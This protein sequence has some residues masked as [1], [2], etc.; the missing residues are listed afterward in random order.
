MNE[1]RHTRIRIGA[2]GRITA[3]CTGSLFLAGCAYQP[4]ATPD[5]SEARPESNPPSTA[6]RRIADADR[7]RSIIKA[8]FSTATVGDD[9][10]DDRSPD[11][12]LTAV[13]QSM[14]LFTQPQ[15]SAPN[16]S[17]N[18]SISFQDARQ[19][20]HT[21]QYII[22]KDHP[23][24]KKIE[25]ILRAFDLYESVGSDD[26]GTVQF[27]GYFAPEYDAS[28]VRTARFKYPIY[29]APADYLNL[30]RNS[31][32][33]NGGPPPWRPR[34]EIE[35][36]NLLEG[37]ELAYLDDPLNVYLLQINGSARL[38]FPNGQGK[39]CVGYSATNN[40]PYTSLGKLLIHAGCA[41]PAKM[42]M[43][44][45][46]EIY[47]RKPAVVIELMKQNDR[48]VF[49]E[50][51]DCNHWPRSS[52]GTTLTP[53]RSIAA[54]HSIFPPGG[55]VVVDLNDPPVDL[56]GD[57]SAAFPRFMLNQDTGGAIKGPARADL[58]IGVGPEAGQIAGRLN[59]TGRLYCLIIKKRNASLPISANVRNAN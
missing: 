41:T 21:F 48:Y 49:F 32:S 30:L 57:A 4:N 5:Q 31:S 50:Q 29:R 19:S 14:A 18:R 36:H 26:F 6:L 2:A 56:T 55:I 44:K 47:E 16:A 43:Q 22:T 54:D 46:R 25:A 13:R 3:L 42:S 53:M 20:L 28:F 59:N 11:S 15:H 38:R 34:R 51:L 8:A 1:P 17:R 35:D 10:I 37:N 12:L 58:F 39:I 7:A 23:D 52:T 45:I 24:S 9:T 27:T 33:F 40:R